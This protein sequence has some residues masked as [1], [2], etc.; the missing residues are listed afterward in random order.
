MLPW[1]TLTDDFDADFDVDAWHGTNVFFRDGDEISRTYLID[2]RGDQALGVAH[3]ATSCRKAEDH[4]LQSPRG[5]HADLRRPKTL[6]PPDLLFEGVDEL[7]GDA[8]GIVHCHLRVHPHAE[9]A[10]VRMRCA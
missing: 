1:Y 6:D 3:V 4:D 8:S 5:G 9:V 2:G 10:S 7:R